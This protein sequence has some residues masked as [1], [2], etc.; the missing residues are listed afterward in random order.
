MK[1]KIEALIK[2]IDDKYVKCYLCKK[3]VLKEN[4][5]LVSF[6]GQ[7]VNKD[8]KDEFMDYE[9]NKCNPAWWKINK[10]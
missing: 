1:S 4:A 6:L 7:G 9:C 2:R 8:F 3:I 10:Q 5:T